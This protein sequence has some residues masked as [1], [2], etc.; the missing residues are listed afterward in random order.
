M[1][2]NESLYIHVGHVPKFMFDEDVP[3]DVGS[4]AVIV[5]SG[6]PPSRDGNNPAD[7]HAKPDFKKLKKQ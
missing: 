4:I 7:L 3:N 6:I 5:F 2:E 1:C